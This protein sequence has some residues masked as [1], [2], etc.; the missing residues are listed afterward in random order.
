[1]KDVLDELTAARRELGKGSL[2]AGEAYT[3]S[4]RR[5]YDAEVEDVW[6][7]LTTAERLQ[8]WFLP[9]SGDLKLGGSYQLQGN[10]G[11]RILG[12]EPPRLLRVSWL[13]GPDAKEGTSE[14]EV[15]L[16]PDP[17]GGTEFALSHSAVVEE[18][19][20]PKY[21]PGA[22]GVG[23]DLGLLSL[24]RHLAGD[25]LGDPSEFEAS[26]A[27]RELSRRSA[28]AWG[29]AH[30]AAGGDP[31]QVAAAVAATTAFYVPEQA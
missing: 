5:R 17:T 18:E 1:M 24:G 20:F 2:P 21:G 4:L 15:R 14:V 22:T 3:V 23:W 25:S 7:A 28:A 8:R 27:A 31:E 30:L 6:D 19:F 10:A 9:V 12:C 13:F 29:E 16:T 26:P 11:G